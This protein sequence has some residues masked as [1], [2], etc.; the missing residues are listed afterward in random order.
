[1]ILHSSELLM[2]LLRTTLALSVMALLVYVLL[3]LVRPSSPS[4]HRAAWILVL[5]AGWVVFRLPVEISYRP[6]TVSEP[7][8]IS[9]A[10]VAPSSNLD[11]R[12][13]DAISEA[14][15]KEIAPSPSILIEP[16]N[17]TASLPET[18][19]EPA[20][21]EEL[22]AKSPAKHAV[23]T[24]PV[25]AFWNWPKMAVA[26]W[27]SGMILLM[28]FW[29]GVYA[30]FALRPQEPVEIEPQWRDQ[31]HELLAR[32]GVRAAI[33]LVIT[34]RVGPMLC[35][36]P[37]GYRLF[38]PVELWR[39][40][41]PAG[42]ESV[43]RHELT[44]YR[45]GDVWKSFAARLLALPH[46]FN[47]L[48][49]RAVRQFDEAAEWACDAAARGDS[50]TAVAEY[51]K[52]LLA[53]H[54][55]AGRW[56]PYRSAAWSRG[57]SQRIRRLAESN[58]SEDS[59]MKKIL[60]VGSALVLV[61][62]C[63]IRIELVAQE[64]SQQSPP[65]ATAEDDPPAAVQ[66]TVNPPGGLGSLFSP[67]ANVRAANG[68]PGGDNV[69]EDT[70]A[71][72]SASAGT[73]IP[74]E[75]AERDALRYDGKGF[76]QWAYE[77]KTELKV[78]YKV[79]AI[80]A[81]TEFGR[82]GYGREAT[83]AIL[84]VMQYYSVL[85]ID[86]SAPGRLKKAAL[87]A[88]DRNLTISGDRIPPIDPRKSVPVLAKELKSE[89]E[90]RR[91][92]AATALERLGP[93]AK[94][95]VD[96]LLQSFDTEKND[97]IARKEAE[98][99]FEADV[100]GDAMILLYRK[101]AGADIEQIKRWV[102]Y[103]QDN[104]GPNGIFNLENHPSEVKL[105]AKGEKIMNFL[106]DHLDA[107]NPTV[108]RISI[109]GLHIFMPY[110]VKPEAIPKIAKIIADADRIDPAELNDAVLFLLSVR[111]ITKDAA[112]ALVE[113]FQKTDKLTIKTNIALILSSI[114]PPAAKIALPVLSEASRKYPS[115]S[116]ENMNRSY[117]EYTSAEI[118][119]IEALSTAFYTML[120]PMPKQAA[121]AGS[122]GVMPGDGGMMGPGMM[123]P[124]M[125]PGGNRGGPAKP[126]Y[127]P[128]VGM[129]PGAMGG[130]APPTFD[131]MDNWPEDVP[132][133]WKE[134]SKAE[135]NR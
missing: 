79:E 74:A 110:Y 61:S 104:A 124:G 36:L 48:A 96:A 95:A 78:E 45:R 102:F 132:K 44:H 41:S 129:P 113:A 59:I 17:A 84:D 55:W 37:R 7:I 31:W 130:H 34:N 120:Q 73:A 90:N 27:L 98:A 75:I 16:A 14:K 86:D 46:W 89:N 10:P 20:N 81:L 39:R 91:L 133:P 12:P 92:F 100:T 127:G 87:D 28:A 80:T 76:A 121:G 19:L 4:L 51:A 93:L 103:T 42:R 24:M 43:L 35:L 83:E 25:Q 67:A 52:S 18:F 134:E 58:F 33:P 47:P 128:P 72:N 117:S 8:A 135:E 105:T 6:T 30:W 49:W 77:L 66:S 60:V 111:G 56:A 1:M 82:R 40:L 122:M 94:D 13:V 29:I 112:P 9:Q 65:V 32:E 64:P 126:G 123:P 26:I 71:S 62:V 15:S 38:V 108:R 125:G 101:M 5:A 118:R 21:I 57:I 11:D 97:N 2:T 109:F 131:P 68:L 70:P 119:F 23:S 3:R 54:Q 99:L 53:L 115:P 116:V 22:P 85:T 50:P 63:L 114:G 88:F 106:V 107:D 69:E